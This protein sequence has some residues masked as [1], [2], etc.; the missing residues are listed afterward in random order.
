MGRS[1]ELDVAAGERDQLAGKSAYWYRQIS[2]HFNNRPGSTE[3]LAHHVETRTALS[4]LG[5][6][7]ALVRMAR[8]SVRPVL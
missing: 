1:P 4:S 5:L 6:R 3:R 7:Q 8:A 2:C